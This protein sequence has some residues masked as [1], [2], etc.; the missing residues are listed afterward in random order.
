MFI[1]K[2]DS[3]LELS[4]EVIFPEAA[5]A[6]ILKHDKWADVWETLT[7][8][9]DLNYTDE[10]ETVSL[11]SLVMS[12]TSAIYQAITDGWTMC[13]GY[14][15][16]KDSHS[17]LHLFLMALIRAVRNGTNI[18]EHHFI[19]MSDTLIENPEMHY[20]ASQVLNQLRMFI[21][22]HQLP[23][24][25][26]VARPSLTQSWVGRILTGRGLPTWTNSSTRQCSTDYKI[27]PL[28]QAKARYLKNAP[29]SVRSRVCLMLGSRDDESARRAG[30]ILKMGGQA[31]KVTLTEHGGELYPV[32][33]WR[34]QDIWSFLMAC[35]SESRFP[36][37][38]FMPDNFSL[39]T[40][41]KDATGECIWSPEKP[42]RTSACG[43]RYGC[44]LTLVFMYLE[45]NSTF[46]F[47]EFKLFI[48]KPTCRQNRCCKNGS[49]HRFRFLRRPL[50]GLNEQEFPGGKPDDVYSVRTS[51]NTPPAEEEIEEERRLFYVGITRTKQQLNLVVPLDEGLARWLK[52]RWDSTPKKSPIATRFVYEAGWT[53]CA[54]TSDAIYNSTVEK[55]KADFSKFHQWYL[56]DLQRLKV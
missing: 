27:A 54:V 34:T 17:L 8:D 30:N 24:T 19:Q 45:L 32:K 9:A 50:I 51:M 52:N 5:N 35:G 20:Q 31:R 42:T 40:L 4:S 25:V 1:E 48:S 36:L 2:S 22:E 16:G 14:S 56:R 21:A 43:A 10:K 13:V 3:F 29:A 41:Y 46:L 11:S 47:L 12:A 53:A 49:D 28:R 55:Q 7:T 26:L 18:S 39:A 15:G 44:S 37:P 33:E 23:V 38:S 6:A